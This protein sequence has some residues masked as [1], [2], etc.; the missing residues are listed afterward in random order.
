MLRLQKPRA[1]TSSS[2]GDRGI[3]RGPR[4]LHDSQFP[5][6]ARA[7]HILSTDPRVLRN[8]SLHRQLAITAVGS[9]LMSDNP[10]GHLSLYSR[11][12]Q[13][14]CAIRAVLESLQRASLILRRRKARVGRLRCCGRGYQGVETRRR[15]KSTRGAFVNASLLDYSRR[16][17]PGSCRG[18][19]ARGRRTEG[20]WTKGRRSAIITL[21]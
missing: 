21:R 12:W 20:R 10:L 16:R 17:P 5:Y 14:V 3:V 9:E 7:L 6:L 11:S 18:R 15:L 2:I 4:R 19:H 8:L 13:G 1:T